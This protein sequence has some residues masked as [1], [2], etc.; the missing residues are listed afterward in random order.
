MVDGECEG[1]DSIR[2]HVHVGFLVGTSG[3]K[4]SRW[5]IMKYTCSGRHGGVLLRTCLGTYADRTTRWFPNTK[6]SPSRTLS[7]S[8]CTK[9]CLARQHCR[10]GTSMCAESRLL[11]PQDM[12]IEFLCPFDNHGRGSEQTTEDERGHSHENILVDLLSDRRKLSPDIQSLCCG[13]S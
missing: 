9:T 13:F 4:C 6:T 3:D 10:D 11:N 12:A 5:R 8:T 7:M 2:F 1:A